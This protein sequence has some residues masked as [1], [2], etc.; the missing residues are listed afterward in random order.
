ME[1]GLSHEEEC[2]SLGVSPGRWV[3]VLAPDQ[4]PPCTD[5]RDR[6]TAQHKQVESLLPSGVF[7]LGLAVVATTHLVALC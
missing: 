5:V 3:A 4:Q 1:A 2:G 6:A 7:G